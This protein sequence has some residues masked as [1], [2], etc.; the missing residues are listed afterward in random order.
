MG[1]FDKIIGCSVSDGQSNP[2]ASISSKDETISYAAL[3]ARYESITRHNDERNEDLAQNRKMRR[4]YANKIFYFLIFWNV[5]LFLFLFISASS[6]WTFCCKFNIAN[7]VQMT[8]AGS[9]AATVI[10]LVAFVVKGLFP[11]ALE[12]K[13]EVQRQEEKVKEK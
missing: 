3:M 11:V 9:T 2:G 7:S 6:Y 8:L 4:E 12:Q 1:T 10:G 13:S 5:I